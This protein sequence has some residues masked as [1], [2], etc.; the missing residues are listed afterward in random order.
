[1]SDVA[2]ALRDAFGEPTHPDLSGTAIKAS[3][4]FIA[5]NNNPAGMRAPHAIDAVHRSSRVDAYEVSG[6]GGEILLVLAEVPQAG[7]TALLRLTKTSAMGPN[8]VLTAAWRFYDLPADATPTD[9]FALLVER[10]GL[11]VQS[12]SVVGKFIARATLTGEEAQQP[13]K[14]VGPQKSVTFEGML[15]MLP[16]GRGTEVSWVYALD[17]SAYAAAVAA[18]RR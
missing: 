3:D 2:T 16:G 13:M 10:F 17:D 15:R 12:G 11:E 4:A 9:A 18:A 1:M 14:L 5:A 8:P 7:Y 6:G